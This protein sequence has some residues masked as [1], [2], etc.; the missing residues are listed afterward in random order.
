M[1][2]ALTSHSEDSCVGEQGLAALAAL[3]AHE[4]NRMALMPVTTKALVRGTC[5]GGGGE[6]EE[7]ECSAVL[8][9][10]LLPVAHP[11]LVLARS[12]TCCPS[13]C[14]LPLFA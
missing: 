6:E 10:E 3:A 11:H 12:S 9:G 14:P 4:R 13:L 5:G 7:E 2:E 8:E 1:T